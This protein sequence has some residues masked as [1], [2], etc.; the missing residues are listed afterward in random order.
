MAG[1]YAVLLF[2]I[3]LASASFLAM[4][5]IS[6]ASTWGVAE[7]LGWRAKIGKKFSLAKNFY[8]VYLMETLPAALIPLFFNDL[9]K[10]MLDLMGDHVLTRSWKLIYWSC[11]HW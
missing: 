2:G 6:L 3:G 9:V 7:A 1:K 10:L 8:A 4:V 5:A 11:S